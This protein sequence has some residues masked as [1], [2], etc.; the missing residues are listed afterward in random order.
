M[1]DKLMGEIGSIYPEMRDS[2]Y[3]RK[4]THAD[5]GLILAKRVF[6]FGPLT[7]KISGTELEIFII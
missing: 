7:N 6:I 5:A 2:Y 1:R 4:V 3:S